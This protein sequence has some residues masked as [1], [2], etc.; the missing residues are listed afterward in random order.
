[1]AKTETK[2]E[3]KT[4]KNLDVRKI[5]RSLKCKFSDS[6]VLQLGRDLAE[7]TEQYG[8]LE[9]D[10]KQVTKDFDAKLAEVDAQI[11]SASGKVQC[12][13]EY[14]AVDCTET[15]GEP[16]DNKKT[17][18]RMDTG[19]IIEVRELS[20]EEKQRLL[21]FRSEQPADAAKLAEL[22]PLNKNLDVPSP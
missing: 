11:R 7:K 1:M 4:N 19:E 15:L 10:K 9:A 3:E 17:V 18:R 12:G 22:L 5:K 13:Y 14:R 21:D 2:T 8:Q 16:D 6:E 20:A